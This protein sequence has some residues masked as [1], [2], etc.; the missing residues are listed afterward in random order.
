MAAKVIKLEVLRAC[1]GDCLMLHYGT[2]SKPGL[3]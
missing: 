1:K 3:V 2:T